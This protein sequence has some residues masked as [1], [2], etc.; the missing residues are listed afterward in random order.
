M[1]SNQS[2]GPIANEGYSQSSGTASS[3][4][5]ITIFQTRDPTPFDFQYPVKKRWVNLSEPSE[6]ILTG[7]NN[8]SGQSLAVW[9]LLTAGQDFV[10]LSDTLNTVVSP[11]S[12]G[13][14]QIFGQVNTTNGAFELSTVVSQPGNNSIQINPMSPARWIVDQA[15]FNGSSTTIASAVASAANG[16]TIIILPG[17]YT[18]NITISNKN[19]TILGMMGSEYLPGVILNGTI[20]VNP[21]SPV[22]AAVTI[23]NILMQAT[24]NPVLS[25]SGN[26]TATVE[27]NNVFINVLSSN[28]TAI[29]YPNSNISSTVRIYNS[30]FNLTTTLTN[31]FAQNS[32]GI[33]EIDHCRLNNTGGSTTASTNVSGTFISSFSQYAAPISITNNGLIGMGYCL[34]DTSNQNVLP[35]ILNGA[36]TQFIKHSNFNSGTASTIGIGGGFVAVIEYCDINCSNGATNAIT[37][38]G[39]LNYNYLSYSGSSSIVSSLLTS[40]PITGGP[41]L[42]LAPLSSAFGTAKIQIMCGAGSPNA[43]ITATKGSI[44]SRTDPADATSRIYVNTDG[45]TTWTNITCAA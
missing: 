23:A 41:V 10:T 25:I 6:W 11:N 28:N 37:G 20:L 42:Q 15:G 32:A 34:I 1:T 29:N 2:N 13:N 14:I 31:Y 4:P 24:N 26:G 27:C 44:F 30:T 16:D 9:V 45:G 36:G 17:T 38:N 33:L 3:D 18:E 43:T 21:S 22:T 39:T 40:I 8:T 12:S 5:F 35:L 19:L 7:F